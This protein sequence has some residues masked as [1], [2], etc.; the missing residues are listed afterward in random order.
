MPEFHKRSWSALCIASFLLTQ[1]L[2]VEKNSQIEILKRLKCWAFRVQRPPGLKK[3]KN[4]G[5]VVKC[6]Q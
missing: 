3:E 6:S 4:S 5:P 2:V 1:G